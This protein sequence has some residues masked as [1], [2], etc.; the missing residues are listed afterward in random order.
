MKKNIR[1]LLIMLA[2][3]VVLGGGA[4][5]L[6]LTQQPETAEESSTSSTTTETVIDRE[7]DEIASIQVKNP[8]STFLILPLNQDTTTAAEDEDS[9]SSDSVQFTIDGYQ[10]F[11]LDTAEVTGAATTVVA[12]YASKDLGEQED[13]AQFG[14]SGENATQVTVN[15]T[16]GSTD[17]FVVGNEA[18]ESSG[19]Y[20]LK[21]GVVYI[22]SSFSGAL[23]GTPLD[24]IQKEVYSVADRVEETV[25]SEGSSSETTLSDVLYHMELTGTHLDQPIVIDY[26]QSKVS[27]YLITEPVVA[28]SGSN[29]FSEIVTALKSL[30]ADSVAATGRTQEIL[31]QYGL[32]DPYA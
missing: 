24:F 16:D 4:A 7:D 28:E 20:L 12:I 15:Y 13:L 30:T 5:A 32:A 25:D 1:Y 18:G 19:R 14:L 3:L 2:V 8:S 10:G 17:E 21:D 27:T 22:S 11:D 26:D 31:E 9:S 29:Q 23:L 6:L